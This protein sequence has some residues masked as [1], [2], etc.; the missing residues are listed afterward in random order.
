LIPRPAEGV[1]QGSSI[2]SNIE[3]QIRPSLPEQAFMQTSYYEYEFSSP[4]PYLHIPTTTFD[5]QTG[6]LIQLM[7][8]LDSVSNFTSHSR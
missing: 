1:N 2:L 6:Y 8:T 4:N 5:Q 7:N 3:L